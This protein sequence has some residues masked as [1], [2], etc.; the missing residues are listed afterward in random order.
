MS[1][2]CLRFIRVTVS[3]NVTLTPAGFQRILTS[4]KLRFGDEGFLNVVSKDKDKYYWIFRHIYLEDEVG[5]GAVVDFSDV[6]YVKTLLSDG[7]Y[8]YL[9]SKISS[10]PVSDTL[11]PGT[12]CPGSW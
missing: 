2:W 4:G 10:G 12:G 3:Q 6:G 5:K 8:A 11:I 1:N 9:T 7:N